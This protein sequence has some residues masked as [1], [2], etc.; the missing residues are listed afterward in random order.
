MP[1]LSKHQKRNLLR[2]VGTVVIGIITVAVVAFLASRN[3]EVLEPKGTI[4]KQQRDLIAFATILSAFI[5]LPVFVLT[6]HIVRTYRVDAKKP[7]KYTPDWDGSRNLELLWWGIPGVII[8]ILSVITWQ[9]THALDPSKAIVSNQAP[10]EVQ[11][12]ALQWKWLFLYPEQHIASVNYLQMPVNRPV[13]FTITA[14][15]P[16]NSFWIPQLGGQVYAMSGM[17]SKLNLM[18]TETGIF[19]GSSAN[20]S[21]EGFADMNFQAQATT[22]DVF[23]IWANNVR[24]QS[25]LLTSDTYRTLALPGVEKTPTLYKFTDEELYQSVVNKYMSHGQHA[26]LEAA[27]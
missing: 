13:R 22:P 8:L 26:Q 23:D 1:R 27:Q 24:Q 3:F 20:I 9:T 5:I 6:F 21:G 7:A 12:I 10:L 17:N 14:D 11:V 16:M 25:S 4:A 18:A 2:L 19:R 15:A